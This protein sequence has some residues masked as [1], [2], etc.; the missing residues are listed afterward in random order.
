MTKCP[1]CGRPTAEGA[2]CERCGA[3]LPVAPAGVSEARASQGRDCGADAATFG[4]AATCCEER[5]AAE[6]CAARSAA[7]EAMLARQRGE[8]T[9]EIDRL[10]PLFE[11]MTGTLRFR[12]NPKGGGDCVENVVI[13]FSNDDCAKRPVQRIRRAVQAQEFPVQFPPQAAGMQSWR[14][15]VEY[16]SSRRKHELTGDFQVIVRPVESRKRG[17]DNFNIKI[18]TNVGNVSQASDVTVNQRGAEGLANLIAATD[19]FEEMSRVFLSDKRQW[20]N[21]PFSDDNKV[22]DLPPMPARAQTNHIAVTL[23]SKRFHFF[24]NRTVKFGRTKE[25]NDIAL[26]PA[27]AATEAETAPYRMVSREHCLFEHAGAN[28]L[29][30]DGRRDERGVLQPST[31]GT[32]WNDERIGAAAALPPGTRGIVSFGGPH[33]GERVSMDLT[34]CEP[35]KACA[36][37]PHANIHWCGEGKRPTL[38]LSRRDGLS[39]TFVA[40]W[41]CFWLGAADPSFEGVV[42]FRKDGAFAYRCEDGRSGW[43]V[44]GTSVQTDFGPATVN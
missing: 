43:L 39:E 41:S 1:Q 18:E 26:R 11:N 12:F 31:H 22:V 34:V 6:A 30:T 21:I 38:M 33:R 7:E 13:T 42:I 16:A 28:V 10:C 25:T 36:T 9:L 15:T 4:S 27:P 17:S 8:P 32:F 3:E 5:P 14:V 37:C 44:P 19:P 2:F 20:A 24:A 29:L 35:A 23:G 40:L